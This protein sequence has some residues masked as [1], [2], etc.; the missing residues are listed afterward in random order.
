MCHDANDPARRYGLR[1][2]VNQTKSAA[3]SN[4][5]ALMTKY[6][7]SSQL[8]CL[9]AKGFRAGTKRPCGR[10]WRDYTRQSHGR[11]RVLGRHHRSRCASRFEPGRLAFTTTPLDEEGNPLFELLNT[12]DLG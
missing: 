9:W 6:V 8:A 12:R 2:L 11:S 1:W 10:R 4:Y 3:I 7:S 5:Q